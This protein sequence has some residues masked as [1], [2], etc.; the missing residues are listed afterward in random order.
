VKR[1]VLWIA[2][3]T[4]RVEWASLEARVHTEWARAVQ[5]PA[6]WPSVTLQELLIS[7][8]DHRFSSH[9]GVD[10]HAIRRCVWRRLTS[11]RIE[12]ASTIAQQLTRVLTNRYEPS[13][14]RKLREMGLALLLTSKLPREVLP[15]LYLRV[16]YYGWQMNGLAAAIDRLELQ[17]A[18]MSPSES[19]RLVARLKYPEPHFASQSRLDH[20]A[21]R[22]NHLIRL[23]KMHSLGSAY[24]G[25]E[26]GALRAAIQG[27]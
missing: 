16:G 9:D 19:A 1:V 20:I 17:H 18:S 2:K 3:L 22:G 27:G 8:E 5:D 11:G 26:K 12:G 4:L 14:T 13:A 15:G 7:G 21:T 23:R 6:G 24:A 10:L 25:L